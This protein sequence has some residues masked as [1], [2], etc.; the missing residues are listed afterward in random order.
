[1]TMWDYSK[2][3]GKTVECNYRQEDV[4][5]AIGLA[6]TT[7][8]LKINNKAEFKQ[9]EIEGICLFLGIPF[10]EIPEYFFKEVV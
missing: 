6:Q 9:S 2:L 3:K 4:G 1:M 5:N 7:Y 8:S 10:R